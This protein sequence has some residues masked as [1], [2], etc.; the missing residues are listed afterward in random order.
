MK[1]FMIKDDGIAIA[2]VTGFSG[3]TLD[4][5]HVEREDWFKKWLKSV[6]K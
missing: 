6:G 1:T 3:K 4:N 5:K 2:P